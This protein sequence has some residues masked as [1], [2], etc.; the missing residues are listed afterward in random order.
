MSQAAAV[1]IA[2]PQD[3]PPV[4]VQAGL[5]LI[6]LVRV[7][8][9]IEGR[10]PKAMETAMAG[11]MVLIALTFR[12]RAGAPITNAGGVALRARPPGGG[13]VR[14]YA[15]EAGARPGE[16]VAQIL[17]DTPGRWWIEGECATPTPAVSQPL[18]VQVSRRATA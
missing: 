12:D 15:T 14:S 13:A 8:I 2:S 17:L 16:W 4:V 9:D 5:L 3:L 11:E 18:V 10:R 1:A 6:R 7:T